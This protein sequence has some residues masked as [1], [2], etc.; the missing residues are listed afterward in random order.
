MHK[1]REM[2][3][4]SPGKG[5]LRPVYGW[6]IPFTLWVNSPTSQLAYVISPSRVP[7]FLRS[8]LALSAQRRSPGEN[9]P[10]DVTSWDCERTFTKLPGNLHR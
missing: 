6:L 5:F 7:P 10:S 9:S 1:A 3:H 8:T 4:P 2:V